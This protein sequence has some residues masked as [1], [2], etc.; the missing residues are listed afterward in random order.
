MDTNHTRFMNEAIKEAK[1]GLNEGG[2]PIGSVIVHKDKINYSPS[3]IK[4]TNRI[5]H[6]FFIF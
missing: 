5:F 2:I 6:S 1:I 3:Y 4:N